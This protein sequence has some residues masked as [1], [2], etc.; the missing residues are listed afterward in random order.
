MDI[1]SVFQINFIK[2]HKF[3]E[4]WQKFAIKMQKYNNF[5]FY[6]AYLLLGEFE[7]FSKEY[8][9]VRGTLFW[10]KILIYWN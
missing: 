6:C 4:H 2:Y 8:N 10:H 9:V 5:I 1:N 3:K 7:L